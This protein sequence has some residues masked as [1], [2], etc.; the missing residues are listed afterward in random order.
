M[1]NLG[2]ETNDLVPLLLKGELC[3]ETASYKI[4]RKENFTVNH[5]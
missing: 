2:L 5:C 1:T 4:L 3:K